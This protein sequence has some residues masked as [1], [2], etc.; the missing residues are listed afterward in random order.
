MV[1]LPDS[2]KKLQICLFVLTEYTNVT[3]RRTDRHRMTT[4]AAHIHSVARKKRIEQVIVT[5]NAV[6]V[7]SVV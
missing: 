3:D 2:D 5:V 4:L 1:W 6:I 7:H